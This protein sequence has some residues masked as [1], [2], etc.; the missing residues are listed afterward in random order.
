MDLPEEEIDAWK[1]R[2]H[3]LLLQLVRECENKNDASK[4]LNMLYLVI[5]NL[6]KHPGQDK[7]RKVALPA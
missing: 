7:Y 3:A 2:V 6:R 4:T 5:E 1:A